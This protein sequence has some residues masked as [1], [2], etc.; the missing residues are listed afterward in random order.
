MKKCSIIILFIFIH[1]MGRS[2]GIPA[3]IPQLM[4][5]MEQSKPDTQLINIC[6]Q[7]AGCYIVPGRSVYRIDSAARYL[8]MARKLN[9]VFKIPALQ[10][11][12][13]LFSAILHC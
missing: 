4:I 1:A 11:R 13:D 5:R 9:D 8:K 2:Q 3:D 10:N 12:I 7:L 6:I